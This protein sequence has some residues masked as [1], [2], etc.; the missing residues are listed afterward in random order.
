MSNIE[1]GE[2]IRTKGGHIQKV[3]KIQPYYENDKN[4]SEFDYISTE[5]LNQWKRYQFEEIVVTHSKNIIDL[6]EVEDIIQYWYE[7]NYYQDF[8]Y[9]W[10]DKELLEYLKDNKI[11][12]DIKSIVTR[13]MF[14]EMEYRVDE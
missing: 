4:R 6:I 1:V 8:V 10:V 5:T 11:N 2:Y 7:D 3:L 14:K 13:E 9:A 12:E